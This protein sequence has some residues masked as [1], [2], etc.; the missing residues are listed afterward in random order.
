[1]TELLEATEEGVAWLT[2][3]RPDRLNA[4]S[5]AMLQGLGE[6]LQRLGDDGTIGTIVI[7][8]AGRGFC[9][10]GD[11]KTMADRASQGFEDRVEGLRRMHQLPMLLRT[12]PK[13][14]IAMVNGPAVGAGFGLALACD[15]R[16]ASA[17]AR[18][19][20]PEVTIG[21]VPGWAGSQRLPRII[22]AGRAKQLILSG[23]P[24]DAAT[25]AAWGLVNEVVPAD[26]LAARALELARRIAENAPTAVQASKQ[27]VDAGLG[28]GLG[29]A[30][31]ALGAG[32]AAS[33]GDAREGITAFR[34]KRK[35]K[36]T[37][38]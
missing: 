1:M 15:L 21:A 17:D 7:S 28:E 32:L 10:G 11:V 34:E 16:I 22:G 14:V 8:G 29:S 12:I 36:Y 9:T 25:A 20:F 2:L 37:G 13:V 5:P 24:V 19:A 33:T 27:L 31:E 30:L 23:E 4:F 38:N 35:P 18:F 6:A 3:N 26:R